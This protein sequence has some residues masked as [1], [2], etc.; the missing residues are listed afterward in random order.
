MNEVKVTC[1]IIIQDRKILVTQRGDR[2]ARA[3]K[4]E[5]PG[6]KIEKNETAEE[7]I[8]RE[9]KEELNVDISISRWLKPVSHS[10]PD[11]KIKLIPCIAKIVSGKIKLNE[12]SNFRWITKE[13]LN[14][15]Y[16]SPADI[17]VAQQ[18]SELSF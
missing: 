18:L 1:A 15:Q 3:G 11:I 4:W 17:P 9:I 8:V 12:H 6:G 7:C 5:F 14:E 2:M 16:W 13:E 10:Y